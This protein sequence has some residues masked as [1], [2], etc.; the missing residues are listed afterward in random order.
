[1]KELE[2]IS[3]P[4]VVCPTTGRQQTVEACK[5]CSGFKYL[6]TNYNDEPIRLQCTSDEDG[7][8]EERDD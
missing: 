2:I 6:M 7:V 8:M 5:G 1:M 4:S 3:Q